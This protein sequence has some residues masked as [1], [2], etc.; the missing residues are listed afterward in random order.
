MF[1]TKKCS[2]FNIF[3][4]RIWQKKYFLQE[5]CK[6]LARNIFSVR[7]LQE[8][9]FLLESC[10]ICIFCQYLAKNL[11]RIVFIFNQGK[12]V[13]FDCCQLWFSRSRTLQVERPFHV[14]FPPPTKQKVNFCRPNKLRSFIFQCLVKRSI[15]I[16]LFHFFNKSSSTFPRNIIRFLIRLTKHMT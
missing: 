1:A 4:A 13:I 14:I 11:A 16:Y 6:I 15:S 5:T 3:L 8:M 2:W 12:H 9:Y 7:F 10:N